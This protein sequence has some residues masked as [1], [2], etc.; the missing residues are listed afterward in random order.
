MSI[1]HQNIF[2][3][4]QGLRLLGD[5]DDGIYGSRGPCGQSSAGA[6]MRHVLDCYR[7]F[8][9]GLEG[10]RI[11]YDARQRNPQVETDRGVAAEAIRDIVRRLEL[12]EDDLFEHPLQVQVD[13]AAWN[14]GDQLWSGSTVARELQFLLS[15]TV[16][17]YALVAVALRSL[18]FEPGDDFGIAPSTLAHRQAQENALAATCG[19]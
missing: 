18:G 8:L 13:A 12:I 15:H 10:G 9:G 6:H 5:L 1:A 17:H 14:Q 2:F 11:D 4:G 19:G 16:H 3:L 7:C